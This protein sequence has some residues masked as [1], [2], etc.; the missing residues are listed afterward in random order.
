MREQ[1]AQHPVTMTEENMGVGK[2]WSRQNGQSPLNEYD[3]LEPTF[4]SWLGETVENPTGYD[5]KWSDNPV[6]MNDPISL[7]TGGDTTPN[8]RFNYRCNWRK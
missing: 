6:G 5:F 7:C 1:A 3:L 4:V 2:S 8:R